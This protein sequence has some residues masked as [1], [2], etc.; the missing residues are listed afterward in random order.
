MN[1]TFLCWLGECYIGDLKESP[2]LEELSHVTFGRMAKYSSLTVKHIF[3]TTAKSYRAQ[4]LFVLKF[5][6]RAVIGTKICFAYRI[7]KTN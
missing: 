1:I 5:M 4:S 7:F 2:S 6:Y 3:G